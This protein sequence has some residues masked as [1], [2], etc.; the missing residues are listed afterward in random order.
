GRDFSTISVADVYE[1]ADVS[2]SSFYARFTNRDALVTV[3]HERHLEAMFDA[4]EDGLS[5][6]DWGALTLPEVVIVFSELF[7]ESG[8]TD[9]AFL[10]SMQRTERDHPGLMDR[11]IAFERAGLDLTVT[12][13]ARR[14]EDLDEAGTLRLRVGWSALVSTLRQMLTPL[15]PMTVVE[16]DEARL[17]EELAEQFCVYTGLP[18]AAPRGSPS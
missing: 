8:R 4:I 17:L 10:R 14:F 15:S 7:L 11:R 1:R 5:A 12:L 6:I 9:S 16:I 18:R 2:P 13:I 3:L